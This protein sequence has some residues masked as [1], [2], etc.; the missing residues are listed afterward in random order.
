MH[1]CIY[2]YIYIAPQCHD[3]LRDDDWFARK[4]AVDVLG[5]VPARPFCPDAYY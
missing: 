5:K 4:T 2:I 3:L 1:V